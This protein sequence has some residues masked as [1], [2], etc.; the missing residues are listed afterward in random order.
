MNDIPTIAAN[1]AT[2]D[3]RMTSFPIFLVQQKRRIHGLEESDEYIWVSL[4]T[5]EE[6]DEEKAAELED[7]DYHDHHRDGYGTEGYRKS[8]YRDEYVFVQPFFTE[9]GAQRYIDINGHNLREPRIYVESGYRNEEWETIRA[10][11]M[12]L[13]A[14]ESV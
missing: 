5:C 1:L 13:E 11:L 7:A 3:G 4:D 2:Q 9:V 8:Y 14:K 12:G 10:H 6:V